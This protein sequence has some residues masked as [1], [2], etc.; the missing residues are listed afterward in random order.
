VNNKN[1]PAFELDD[2]LNDSQKEDVRIMMSLDTKD[3]INNWMECVGWDDV[4][5]GLALLE[6]A[7]IKELESETQ[8]KPFP[9]ALKIIKKFKVK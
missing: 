7:H 9:D 5:Y 3:E 6:V 8:N 2:E 1:L 4:K